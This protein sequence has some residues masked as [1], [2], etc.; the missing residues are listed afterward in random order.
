MAKEIVLDALHGSRA[1]R[2]LID[3]INEW[4]EMIEKCLKDTDQEIAQLQ[5]EKQ[6]TEM[7]LEAKK[8]PLNG[9]F[10]ENLPWYFGCFI[11]GE[12]TRQ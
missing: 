2:S 9:K 11:L 3:D 4:K 5:A 7:A 1:L 12:P 8:V 10:G 6:N